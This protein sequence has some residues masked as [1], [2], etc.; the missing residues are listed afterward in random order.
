MFFSLKCFATRF[1][2]EDWLLLN[3][4]FM[5]LLSRRCVNRFVVHHLQLKLSNNQ[6]QIITPQTGRLV[7]LT[8]LRTPA[9]VRLTNL[10][11]FNFWIRRLSNAVPHRTIITLCWYIFITFRL[12]WFLVLSLLGLHSI[13]KIWREHVSPIVRHHQPCH[14]NSLRDTSG[15]SS[16]SLVSKGCHSTQI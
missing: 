9:L 10:T 8:A 5:L 12:L 2:E 7:S 13:G 4:D 14:T 6:W 3:K 16:S 11:I 1:L 15:C